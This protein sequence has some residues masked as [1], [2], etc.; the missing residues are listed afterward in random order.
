M[1]KKIYQKNGMIVI[2]N[3]ETMTNKDIELCYL[4]MNNYDTKKQYD[5]Y[6]K[7]YYQQKG[8]TYRSLH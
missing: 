1:L 8:F 6:K 3:D 5:Q 7:D 2:F 4:I